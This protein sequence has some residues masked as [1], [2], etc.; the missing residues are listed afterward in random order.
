MPLDNRTI[1]IAGAGLAVVAALGAAVLLGGDGGDAP[2]AAEPGDLTVDVAEAPAADPARELECYVDGRS[3]GL[4]TL[5][6]CARRNGVA[7]GALDVGIDQSGA[8]VAYRPPP[9]PEPPPATDPAADPTAPAAPEPTPATDTPVAAAPQPSIVSGQVC[10]REVGGGWRV[11]SEGASLSACVKALY[12]GFCARPGTTQ[13]GRWGDTTL[14][15]APGRVEQ[16]SDNV[17]FR[18][19][20]RQDR[21]CQ[22]P[23]L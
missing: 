13:Y 2:S 15:L 12:S 17:R 16:S 22:F 23:E 20:A 4:A 21:A 3:V 18:V 5:A 8:A 7:T 6:D 11:V 9:A 1:V 14:R 10:Q 19:L